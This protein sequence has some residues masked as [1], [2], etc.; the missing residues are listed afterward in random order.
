V[1]LLGNINDSF[2]ASRV[3][4]HG[5]YIVLVT[6]VVEFVRLAFDLIQDGAAKGN[7]VFVFAYLLK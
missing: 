2:L 4:R 7:T 3:A 5:V 6:F 1:V